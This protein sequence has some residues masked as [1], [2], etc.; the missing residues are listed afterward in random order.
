M[1]NGPSADAVVGACPP[2]YIDKLKNC[3]IF[4]KYG[5]GYD[6]VD[7][8]R[9]GKLAIPVCNVPDYGTREVAE[10]AMPWWW[11]WRRA[12]PITTR[13][14][15]RILRAIGGP[16]MIRSDAGCRCALMVCRHGTDRH[17]RGARGRRRF[18][19]MDVVFYDPSQPNGYQFAI[20]VSRT[21]TPRGLIGRWLRQHP[22]PSDRR[23]AERD[24]RGRVCHREEGNDP[25]R[26]GAGA[27]SCDLVRYTTR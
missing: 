25:D 27:R 9:F 17:R 21:P 19:D 13:N 15:G 11:V 6:D 3:R 24:R 22:H 10:H 14:C 1:R 5:V 18:S 20:G 2:Q 4:V 26:Y 8:E 16:R 12:S 7:I 23:D